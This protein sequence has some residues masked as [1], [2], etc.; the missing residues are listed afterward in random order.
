MTIH[1]HHL[2]GCTPTPLSH[3]LKALGILRLVAEQKDPG[4]RGHWQDEHFCLMTTLDRAALESFF[5]KEYA[6]TPFVSPWNRGSGFFHAADGALSNIEGS[7][8]SRFDRFRIGIAASRAQ[9]A[10]LS[11][12]DANVRALKDSTKAKK[13]MTHEQRHAAR[14]RKDDPEFKKALA[15]AERRFKALKADLF[16]PSLR[17][18]RGDHRRWMDAAVV[19]PEEGKASW[20]S[21]LGTGGADGRLDFTN[22]AMQRLGDL[23]DLASPDGSPREGAAELLLQALFGLPSSR[24]TMAAIGQFFPGQAGGANSTSAPEGGSPI[25]PWDLILTLEGSILFSARATRR[26]DPSSMSHA[27]APFAVRSHAAGYATKGRENAERGE[28]WMPLWSQPTSAPALQAMLAEGRLQ[29]GR[30]IAY[31][32]IDVARAL[33]RLGVARGVTGFV[34]F[35]YLERNGQSKIAVPLGRVAVRHR[36]RGRLID[37]IAHWLDQLQRLARD[38]FAPSRLVILEG[39]LADSVFNALAHDEDSGR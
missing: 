25:N 18:W 15:A 24:L 20:P 29:L 14:Q 34:R 32:P 35:G 6:P 9:L 31:R 21:L 28:Q 11:E 22:N 2:V 39:V 12:A 36:P 4:A 7:K 17:S 27:S 16:T 13:G 5:L 3:Y 19:L 37:D 30:Q 1:L 33:A 10:A 26:L 23:F 8:A 38:D